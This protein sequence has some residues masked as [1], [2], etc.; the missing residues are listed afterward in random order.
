ME[1]FVVRRGIVFGARCVYLSEEAA[2][3]NRRTGRQSQKNNVET[4]KYF[5][6]F[7]SGAG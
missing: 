6:L 1:L 7:S 5:T 4:Q 2:S 3:L